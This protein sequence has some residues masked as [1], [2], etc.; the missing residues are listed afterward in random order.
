MGEQEL[1]VERV[2]DEPIA[3]AYMDLSCEGDAVILGYVQPDGVVTDEPYGY[4]TYDAAHDAADLE[5]DPRGEEITTGYLYTGLA[6]AQHCCRPV[7]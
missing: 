7:E 1:V 5:D 4:A 2:G 3:V 6:F